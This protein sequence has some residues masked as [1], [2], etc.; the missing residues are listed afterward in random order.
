MGIRDYA[1]TFEEAKRCL[2]EV[3]VEQMAMMKEGKELLIYYNAT[4]LLK[5]MGDVVLGWMHLW[6]LTITYPKLRNLI[7]EKEGDEKEK[8][9]EASGEAAFYHGKVLGSQYYIGSILRET[10]GKFDQIAAKENAVVE[11][12]ERS[13]A[14]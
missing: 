8:I 4:P 3:V 5:A 6:Q 9:L 2:V 10:F 11:M 14:S 7:G 12:C 13:F 1:E